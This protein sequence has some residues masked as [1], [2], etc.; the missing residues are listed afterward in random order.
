MSQKE[1]YKIHFSKLCAHRSTH[2]YRHPH[3]SVFTE[4]RK[5]KNV[6]VYLGV[7]FVYTC[8]KVAKI[9]RHEEIHKYTF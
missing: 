6:K 8:Y 2:I 1:K 4:Y 9:H 3:G 7:A 5:V